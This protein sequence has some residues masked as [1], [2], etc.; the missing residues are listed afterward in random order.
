M[1]ANLSFI[2]PRFRLQPVSYYVAH[3]S[4]GRS[5]PITAWSRLL[6]ALVCRR[7]LIAETS[8]FFGDNL[9]NNDA[10]SFVCGV[11]GNEPMRQKRAE[12]SLS[13]LDGLLAVWRNYMEGV[14]ISSTQ[15]RGLKSTFDML[16][17]TNAENTE[18]D[19]STPF[20]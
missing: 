6:A 1:P 16:I 11:E 13:V 19:K 5:T 3:T 10:I 20:A 4:V 12:T 18:Y 14:E 15:F 2:L 8:V 9:V 7:F 17:I